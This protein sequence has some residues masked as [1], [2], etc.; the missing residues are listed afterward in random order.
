MLALSRPAWAQSAQPKALPVP[1]KPTKM[2]D[3]PV[4]MP[5]LGLVLLTGMVVGAALI[6]SKRGHKD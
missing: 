3:P 4:I 6:P 5:L 1:P 2:D